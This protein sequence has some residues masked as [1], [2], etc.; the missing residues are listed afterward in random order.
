MTVK[1]KEKNIYYEAARELVRL[2]DAAARTGGEY[3]DPDI[4]GS[5][6]LLAVQAD[7]GKAFDAWAYDV[8][9]DAA[10]EAYDALFAQEDEA[11]EKARRA[12]C[13]AHYVGQRGDAEGFEA[14]YGSVYE[15]A[16]EDGNL[17]LVWPDVPVKGVQPTR[18]ALCAAPQAAPEDG[19][20]VR[21][22]LAAARARIM[23][24]VSRLSGPTETRNPPREASAPRR[25]RHRGASTRS[26]AASGD[27]NSESDD[28]D[29]DDAVIL[30]PFSH[31]NRHPHS[32]PENRYLRKAVLGV[33]Q[34][35]VAQNPRIYNWYHRRAFQYI[36][37]SCKALLRKILPVAALSQSI[38][39][40]V[41]GAAHA[42]FQD[43]IDRHD[44]RKRPNPV[45][46]RLFL[47]LG[48]R[49]LPA[50]FSYARKHFGPRS[51]PEA[52]CCVFRRADGAVWTS[53][54]SSAAIRAALADLEQQE[55]SAAS[56][57][58]PV[59]RDRL[60]GQ[61]A[62][63]RGDLQDAL[64]REAA[65]A[66]LL[67]DVTPRKGKTVRRYVALV[68]PE[69]PATQYQGVAVTHL[70]PLPILGL[71]QIQKGQVKP[72]IVTLDGLGAEG[73]EEGEEAGD[74]QTVTES[75]A[76]GARDLRAGHILEMAPHPTSVLEEVDRQGAEAE[77][78]RPYLAGRERRCWVAVGTI[79]QAILAQAQMPGRGDDFLAEAAT[80][81]VD[82]GEAFTKK[83]LDLLGKDRLQPDLCRRFADAI[84]KAGRLALVTSLFRQPAEASPQDVQVA[85]LK[86]VLGKV[87]TMPP[88]LQEA[89]AA[90]IFGEMCGKDRIGEKLFPTAQ[91][92]R[93]A[94]EAVVVVSVSRRSTRSTAV[95]YTADER[96]AAAV[97][98]KAAQARREEE[99]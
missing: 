88:D 77:D 63:L 86:D 27:G 59:L 12:E 95:T 40:A 52:G 64:G 36:E 83:L 31:I 2:G 33:R 93:E 79:K 8:L 6:L 1:E 41:P 23:E 99:A 7:M 37:A 60:H 70:S 71:K 19:D 16:D 98:L 14:W 32:Q 34:D 21:K 80:A 11:A 5:P 46:E 58:D 35:A 44:F 66:A 10:H 29:P 43:L 17:I 84:A 54:P 87:A 97:L 22:D 25:T 65:E 56:A 51:T 89:R 49:D 55:S 61:S 20:M 9:E 82:Q 73:L 3:Y 85:K 4:S 47:D 81:V 53:A 42:L 62:V 15:D 39:D 26:S 78:Q 72:V 68:D 38:L 57:R 92:G 30:D 18:R 50:F 74:L 76:L 69:Q 67:R 13:L 24:I 94:L 75:L 90:R 45:A 48:F 96:T 28:P 91:R